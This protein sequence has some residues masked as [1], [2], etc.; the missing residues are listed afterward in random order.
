[1]DDWKIQITDDAS[2]VLLS[3]KLTEDDRQVIRD[4]AKTIKKYGPNKLLERPDKWAD[5]A[6]SGKWAGYR[7]SS[8]SFK[9]RIIYKIINE[10]ITVTV[11]RITPDHN[12]KV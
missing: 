9:G 6:L 2:K 10:I 11:V 12:Y 5:H 8:F 1:M 4:W 3:D 7:S